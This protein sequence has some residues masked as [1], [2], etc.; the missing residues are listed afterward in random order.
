MKDVPIDVASKWIKKF[1]AAREAGLQDKRKQNVSQ[2]NAELDKYLLDEIL[3]KRSRNIPL[4][5][6]MI[7][8][9]A[10]NAPTHL[11]NINFKALN[12]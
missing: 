9:L 1:K 8:T 2:L 6:L 5:V 11:K 3:K 7:K 12:G 4:N 10:L